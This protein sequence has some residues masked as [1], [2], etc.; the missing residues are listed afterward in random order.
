MSH[1]AETARWIEFLDGLLNEE[2]GHDFGTAE[3]LHSIGIEYGHLKYSICFEPSNG[4]YRIYY[5]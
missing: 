3:T 2:L 1:Y 5:P 4:H